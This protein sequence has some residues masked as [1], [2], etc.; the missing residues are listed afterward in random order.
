MAPAE[1]NKKTKKT[2]IL[3][4]VS[5]GLPLGLEQFCF[6]AECSSLSR[7]PLCPLPSPLTWMCHSWFQS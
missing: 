1:K 5:L 4:L 2:L 7:E 6:S 3:V